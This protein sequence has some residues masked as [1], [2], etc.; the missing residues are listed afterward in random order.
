M[1]ADNCS[2]FGRNTVDRSDPV[3]RSVRKQ[4]DR[5][6][7]IGLLGRVMVMTMIDRSY[8]DGDVIVN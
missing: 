6:V 4:M 5:A 3:P 7:T 8:R 1:V 2:P